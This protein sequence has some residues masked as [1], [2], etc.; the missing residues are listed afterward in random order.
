MAYLNFKSRYDREPEIP[1]KGFDDQ[2]WAGYEA[3][4]TELKGQLSKF[5]NPVLTIECYPGVRYEEIKKGLIDPLK[6]NLVIFADDLAL[7]N[8]EVNKRIARQMTDDRVFGVMS[9]YFDL[10]EFYIPERVEA[11]QAQIDAQ[12]GLTVIYGFGASIVHEGDIM[13]YSDLARWEIQLRY[14]SKEIANWKADNYD[15]DPLKKYKRGFFFEWRIAD[16]VKRELLKNRTIDYLLDTNLKDDPKMITGEALHKGLETVVRRPFRLVPYFDPG[17]WGGQ[18]MKEVCN[19]PKD[20]ENYAWSFDG[21][22]EENSLYLTYGDIRVEI[23]A[24]NIVIN[25]PI[26][27]LGE[28][29]H[30]RFGN[31]F[32]IRFD[33][34]DTMEGG[35][36]SLQVHPLTEYIQEKFGMAYTQDESYYVLAAKDDAVCYLGVKEGIDPEE[37]IADLE[38]AQRGEGPFNDE[39]FINRFPMKRHD[40]YLIPAGTVH[41]QGS[42][43][44]VLEISTSAYI[45]T[46]KLWDWGRVGL[47]GKPRPVH[48]EHGKENIQFNRDSQWVDKNLVNRIEVIEEGDG[49]RVEKT[50]LH[51]LQ[52][53]ET[54]RHWFT[55]PVTHHTNGGV[56]VLNLVEGECALVESPEG[57]F[58]PFEVHFA[59]T[60]IIPASV[61]TYT[62]R[63]YKESEGKECATIKAYIR[64]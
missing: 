53:I 28:R 18:W 13:V 56:N 10:E 41:C 7:S 50:G 8:D 32:P 27:L 21:V 51:E 58:E 31:N 24:M 36:L 9:R 55:K 62:I 29:V 3:I 64:V 63:P 20:K 47:D 6:P 34:L 57:L 35:N 39:K 5:K 40:H 14:R 15:E 43:S 2:A 37:M 60:F 61:G 26:P 30:A 1:I 59:E 23:P 12:E 19:L 46:F 54:H 48:I 45:F 42:N 44:M 49:Y 4:V 25:Q 16:K 17:V 52:F 33:L 11:A 22:P 38:K